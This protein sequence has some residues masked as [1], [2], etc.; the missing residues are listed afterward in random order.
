MR[1]GLG[2]VERRPLLPRAPRFWMRQSNT[3]KYVLILIG[4]LEKP[5]T[6]FHPKSS[7]RPESHG[8]RRSPS[9][10]STLVLARCRDNRTIRRGDNGNAAE[11]S[12][13]SPLLDASVA[14][15]F[16]IRT[17]SSTACSTRRRQLGQDEYS[18]FSALWVRARDRAPTVRVEE[19][20]CLGACADAPCV[21]IEHD[22]YDGT[23]SLEGMT[24]NEFAR[25]VFVDVQTE[26]DADR[27]WSC[28]EHA[29]YVM[30][31]NDGDDLEESSNF[32]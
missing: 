26:T 31:L 22:E 12:S 18:T 20:S 7:A 14:G 27:I 8:R 11:C 13:T 32:V 9:Q 1:L 5:A 15:K 10:S 19:G 6:A 24:P 4:L 23:V 28:V 16:A 21:A 3:I 30:A 29:I 2:L 17:C 25:R